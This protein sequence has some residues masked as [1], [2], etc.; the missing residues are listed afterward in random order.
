MLSFQLV[1]VLATLR[2]VAYDIYLRQPDG[3]T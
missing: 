1:R 2:S 3:R